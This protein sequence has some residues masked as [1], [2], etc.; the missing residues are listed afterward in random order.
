MQKVARLT[1]VL[2]LVT[3]TRCPLAQAQTENG[4]ASVPNSPAIFENDW[5]R[6]KAS[7]WSACSPFDQRLPMR[8]GLSDATLFRKDDYK[9]YVITHTDHASPVPGGRFIEVSQWIAPWVEQEVGECALYMDAKETKIS[10]RLPRVDYYFDSSHATELAL[11]VCGNPESRRVI[12]YGSSFGEN[13]P[14]SHPDYDECGGYFMS[15]PRIAG[16]HPKSNEGQGMLTISLTF[17]TTDPDY[18]P[19]KGDPELNQV[20]KEATRIVQH[21]KYK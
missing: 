18:L 20:L 13:C 11:E 14:A 9:L 8:E 17:A 6:I 21:I 2:L 10:T 5:L 4:C 1:V 3:T 19:S 12:W 15:Y 7:G 16:R